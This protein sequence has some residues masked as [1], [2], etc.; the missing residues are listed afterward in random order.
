M[1]KISI[2]GQRYGHLSVV[3]EAEPIAGRTAWNCACDCG[4]VVTV[5]TTNLRTG[6]TVSCGCVRSEIQ[7][8]RAVARNT[9]HGHNHRA[10][11]SPTWKSW[12]A[13]LRRCRNPRHV[14]YAYYGG[15]GIGVCERWTSFEN[16]LADM[17]ER[18]ADKTIDR[19]DVDGNYE[20]GNCRWATRSE[21]QRNRRARA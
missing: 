13:M 16:F 5:S 14:S 17:G 3:E 2:R 21:Q 4:R 1:R 20:P 15:R 6:H 12:T 11:P 8:R 18:P 9:V 10:A 7:S 19:I